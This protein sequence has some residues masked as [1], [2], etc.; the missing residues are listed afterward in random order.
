MPLKIQVMSECACRHICCHIC[1]KEGLCLHY[2]L[3]FF[4]GLAAPTNKAKQSFPRYFLVAL[5][6]WLAYCNRDCSLPPWFLRIWLG[7]KNPFL[8]DSLG[9]LVNSVMQDLQDCGTYSL[10]PQTALY[11]QERSLNDFIF[12]CGLLSLDALK[13]CHTSTSVRHGDDQLHGLLG[14]CSPSGQLL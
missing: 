8:R 13:I 6:C 7:G 9:L 14:W 2:S 12:H 4:N 1:M 10:Y 3:Y 5:S 11:P